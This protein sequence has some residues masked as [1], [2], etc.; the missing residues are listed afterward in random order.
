MSSILFIVNTPGFFL[1][2]RLPIAKAALKAGYAV[3]IATA[4]GEE[5]RSIE[6][7]GI[8]FHSINFNRSGQN[9][10][11]ELLIFFAIFRLFLKVRPDVVHAITIKPVLYGGVAARLAGIRSFVA[12]ISGLGTV[13]LAT[14]WLARIRRWFVFFMYRIALR[15]RNVAVI[16]QNSSDRDT[17][18]QLNLLR[19]QTVR[20]IR[21]SGVRL[22]DYP[23]VS[24]PMGKPVVVMVARLLKDKGVLEYVEAA[25]ILRLRGVDIELRLVGSPDPQNP[26]SITQE[27]YDQWVQEGA[28]R[29]LGYRSDIADQYASSNLACLPSYREGLPK[30]LIEAAACGRAVIT[31]DVPG[32]RDSITPGVTGVLVP[33]RDSL[34]LADAIQKLAGDADLRKKMGGAGRR[35]AEECFA[36]EFVVNQHMSIY[37][38]LL[39]DE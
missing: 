7:E 10:L 4:P 22:S 38:E 19:A 1:S 20:M 3:H 25:R 28:V 32:C 13:F 11:Q 35:L 6:S 26:T 34:A 16:F 33:A 23:F 27:L 8:A 29:C 30:S 36:I 24:E 39:G 17:L 12:A 9:P 18:L 15:G 5:K 31:T 14:S 2:H 21:G 37:E